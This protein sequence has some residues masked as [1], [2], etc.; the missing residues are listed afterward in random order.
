MIAVEQQHRPSMVDVR[1]KTQNQKTAEMHLKNCV[2][3]ISPAPHFEIA[4]LTTDF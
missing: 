1:L 3:S 4:S 2:F